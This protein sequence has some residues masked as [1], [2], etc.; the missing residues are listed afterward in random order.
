[1]QYTFTQITYQKATS[2]W[3]RRHTR[4]KEGNFRCDEHYLTSIKHLSKLNL[5]QHYRD[6][7]KPNNY[8]NYVFKTIDL[9][10]FIIAR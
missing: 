4:R 9:L 5:E 7:A 1:M 6:M 2:F 8:K 10:S 3:Q